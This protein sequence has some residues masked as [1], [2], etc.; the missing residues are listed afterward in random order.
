[1]KIK[2]KDKDFIILIVSMSIIILLACLPQIDP[3]MRRLE[4]Q[5]DKITLLYNNKLKAQHDLCEYISKVKR[6]G[7]H[8]DEEDVMLEYRDSLIYNYLY[9]DKLLE[10]EICDYNTEINNL[11]S[12]KKIMVTEVKI[13]E[14]EEFTDGE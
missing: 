5:G 14:M 12:F 11:S 7:I 1:M 8:K 2:K 9:Y 4:E 3:D 13:N 6:L 10:K